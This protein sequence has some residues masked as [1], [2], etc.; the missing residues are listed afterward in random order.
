MKELRV[1]MAIEKITFNTRL[2]RNGNSLSAIIPKYVIRNLGIRKRI[3]LTVT[4]FK[5][6]RKAWQSTKKQT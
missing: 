4:K 3:T 6:G 5:G 1:E 2:V